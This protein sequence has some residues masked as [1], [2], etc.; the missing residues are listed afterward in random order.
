MLE[1]LCVHPSVHVSMLCPE[2]IFCTAQPLGTKLGVVV[3]LC[4]PE[5]HAIIL[6]AI[7]KVKVAVRLN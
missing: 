2:D 4:E 7:L 5:C 3:R 6:D 1:S